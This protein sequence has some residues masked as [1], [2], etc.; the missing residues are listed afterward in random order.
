ML[1]EVV[2]KGGNLLLNVGPAPDGRIQSEF[3]TRLRAMG[4]WL[5]V[6]GEAI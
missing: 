6:N 1:I 3:Q 5:K 2:S 4:R